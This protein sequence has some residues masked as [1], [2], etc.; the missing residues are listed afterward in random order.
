MKKQLLIILTL[1]TTAQVTHADDGA[2]AGSFTGSMFG[3]A[4]SNAAFSGRSGRSS[5][6]HIEKQIA[7]VEADI[8]HLQDEISELQ[9]EIAHHESLTEEIETDI[10]QDVKKAKSWF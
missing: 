3:S 2:F 6:Y 8:A 7:R 4:F 5:C 10:R 1:F 9:S